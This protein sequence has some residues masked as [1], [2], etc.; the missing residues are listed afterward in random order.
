M[1]KNLGEEKKWN[2]KDAAY[3]T[4][5]YFIKWYK[6]EHYWWWVLSKVD[7][8]QIEKKNKIVLKRK[9]GRNKNT[10]IRLGDNQKEKKKK[11][12]TFTF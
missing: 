6:C 7:D 3:C 4:L 8:I 12:Q 1:L 11:A 5:F 10:M 2:Q 9:S